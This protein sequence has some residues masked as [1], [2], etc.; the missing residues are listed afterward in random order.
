MRF[1]LTILLIFLNALVLTLIYLMERREAAQARFEEGSRTLFGARFNAIDYVAV[2]G[3]E[4]PQSWVLERTGEDQWMLAEPIR[5]SANPFAVRRILNEIT[6]LEREASFTLREIEQ[7]GQTLA[8]YGLEDPTATLTVGEGPERA[9]LH[10]GEV[11]RVGNRLYLLAPD[12]QKVLVVSRTLLDSLA[13]NLEEL[14][15]N[16]VFSI[17]VFEARGISLH[18]RDTEPSRIRLNREAE[19]DWRFEVP[20]ETRADPRKV[21]LF[22]SQLT[23]MQIQEF[24]S[25]SSPNAHGLREP[26][27][28]ITL[29]GNQRRETL[30]LGD[31]LTVE[32]NNSP[33]NPANG[34]SAGEERYCA[35]LENNPTVFTLPVEPLTRLSELHTLLRDRDFLRLDSDELTA[36]RIAMS[37]S[38]L[39]LQKLEGGGW[40]VSDGGNGG[41]QVEDA[42][43]IIMDGLLLSLE[44]LFA[45][46]FVSDAPSREDL[47]SYGLAEPT[48][49][50]TLIREEGRSILHFGKTAPDG[51]FVYATL[52]S[53]PFVYTVRPEILEFLPPRPAFFRIRT[54]ETLPE[55][56][57]MIYLEIARRTRPEET[58]DTVD[59][60]PPTSEGDWEILFSAGSAE[61]ET[62]DWTQWLEE[63]PP[64]TAE[65]VQYLR[66]FV[67]TPRAQTYLEDSFNSAYARQD[68]GLQWQYRLE[69]VVLL[70]S[71]EGARRETYRYYFSP[72]LGGTTQIGGSPR[73]R[74]TFTLNQPMIDALLELTFQ[75][76]ELTVPETELETAPLP[77]VPVPA[78]EGPGDA[79][80]SKP[81]ATSPAPDAADGEASPPD[82]G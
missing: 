78:A 60:A 45:M 8:D 81:S 5:W 55:S 68:D 47:E 16:S 24:V 33:G 38:E 74:V 75:R 25:A 9:S 39:N 46:E 11:T 4:L 49:T 20:V 64:E 44:N 70:P 56:A 28:R 10:I 73:H 23:G 12:G 35:R 51:S 7:A 63:Q 36:I 13:L 2:S 30:L 79:E 48:R 19:E 3:G 6:L 22:L 31:R 50:V 66:G 27:A 53:E 77:E 26:A 14:R 71:G 32:S 34:E 41:I 29:Q 62:A 58:A 61:A 37:S 40:Q 80:P 65:A 15:S 42:E 17:P 1:R 21:E 57:E 82:G 76:A 67:R 18:L 69:G 72:R 52:A 43:P 54:L 59:A